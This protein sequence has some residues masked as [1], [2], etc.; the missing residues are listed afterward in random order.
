MENCAFVDELEEEPSKVKAIL[1]QLQLKQ[2][3]VTIWKFEYSERG[4]MRKLFW[5][6]GMISKVNQRCC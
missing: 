2:E 1:L 3:R 6:R 5:C 4:L